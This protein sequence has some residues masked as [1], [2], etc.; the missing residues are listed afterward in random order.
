[1]NFQK[2]MAALSKNRFIARRSWEEKYVSPGNWWSKSN[3]GPTL[4]HHR[5][6]KITY[7]FG[8]WAPTEEDIVAEDW[9][10]IKPIGPDWDL[11]LIQQLTGKR[12]RPR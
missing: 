6:E 3:Y 11:D 7:C 8:K 1:M 12:R 5:G 4:I 10:I 2:A 9:E